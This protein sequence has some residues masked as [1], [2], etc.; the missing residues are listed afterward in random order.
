MDDR[1][2]SSSEIPSFLPGLPPLLSSTSQC[3]T[4]E[5]MCVCVWGG[6]DRFL[7]RFIFFWMR[8]KVKLCTAV[9]AS[10]SLLFPHEK[11]QFLS[12]SLCGLEARYQARDSADFY[13]FMIGILPE[14]A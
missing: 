4:S 1:G 2:V 13:T 8:F 5:D 6:G 7:P 12:G 3:M 9:S 10:Q 11:E 14:V